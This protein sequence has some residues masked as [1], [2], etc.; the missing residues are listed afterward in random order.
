M[1]GEQ[2]IVFTLGQEYYA[3]AISQV[4]EIIHYQGSTKLPNTPLYMEGIINLRGK[5]LPVIDLAGKFGI[6]AG[7]GQD[8][9]AV[10]VEALGRDVGMLVDDVTE[11]LWLQETAI[12]PPPAICACRKEY[13]RGVGKDKDRLLIL[14]ELE[15]LFADDLATNRTVS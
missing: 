2:F 3:I 14:L 15:N 5:L 8:R 9:R 13:I 1:D 10:I 12:E 11:V 6:Q 4:K 7:N